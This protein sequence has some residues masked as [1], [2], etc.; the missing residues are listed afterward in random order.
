MSKNTT[1]PCDRDSITDLLAAAAMPGLEEIVAPMAPMVKESDAV[2]LLLFLVARPS[3]G[4]HKRATSLLTNTAVWAMM[5]QSALQVGRVLPHAAPTYDKLKHQRAKLSPAVVAEVHEQLTAQAVKLAQS[6]GMLNPSAPCD[7][8]CPDRTSTVVGDATVFDPMADKEG[9][10]GAMSYV[11]KDPDVLDLDDGLAE[12]D[13]TKVKAGLPVSVAAVRSDLPHSRVLLGASAYTDGNEMWASLDLLK[14]VHRCAGGGVQAYAYDRLFT[15]PF[16]ARV[17]R[18]GIVPVARMT[19]AAPKATHVEVDSNARVRKAHRKQRRRGVKVV[20]K[21][22]LRTYRLPDWSHTLDD[23]TVCTHA[24]WAVDG[25][26]VVRDDT[27]KP[28][29]HDER[30]PPA[31]NVWSDDRRSLTARYQ[32]HRPCGLFNI[33]LDLGSKFRKGK[34]VHVL[35]PVPESSAWMW[36][37]FGWREDIESTFSKLKSRFGSNGRI[38]AATVAAFDLDLVGLV[39]LE[40]AVAWDVHV[41]VHTPA[42][43]KHAAR[44]S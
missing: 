7:P 22:R 15:D 41:G 8:T 43:K 34:L 18:L 5:R 27:R 24:C 1:K 36:K 9:V 11:N 26:L 19:A 10:R 16:F 2:A 35:R 4:S 42:A 6:I 25:S 32:V 3:E 29:A 37:M 17:M 44:R 39:L 23:G 28:D 14:R 20:Q 12:P 21:K 31:R 40:N 13:T 30:L 38:G 33:E